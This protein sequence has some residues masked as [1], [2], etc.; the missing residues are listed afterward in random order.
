MAWI[1]KT[2][3]HWPLTFVLLAF[4]TFSGCEGTETRDKVDD[5]VKELSGQKNIERMDQMK[6]NIGDINTQQADRLK[7]PQ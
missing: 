1:K 2:S 3:K 4:L 5:T 7:E 6:K